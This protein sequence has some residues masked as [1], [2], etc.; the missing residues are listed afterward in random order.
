VVIEFC[1]LNH[2]YDMTKAQERMGYEPKD[3][4]EHTLERA[5]MWEIERRDDL[6]KAEQKMA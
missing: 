2:T 3:D 4:F 5:V 6:L 1:L